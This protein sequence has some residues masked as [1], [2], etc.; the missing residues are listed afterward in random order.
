MLKMLKGKRTYFCAAAVA[1][2]AALH[3]LGLIN[4][5]IYQTLGV[6]FASG[7]LASLRASMK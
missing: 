1:L 4:D 6:I 7:G 3:H 5:S 2:T